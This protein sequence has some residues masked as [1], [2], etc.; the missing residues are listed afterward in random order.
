MRLY[1]DEGRVLDPVSDL[2]SVVYKPGNR[3]RVTYILVDSI[4]SSPSGTQNA[5]YSVRIK[6]LQPVLVKPIMSAGEVASPIENEDPVKLLSTPWFGG[7]YLNMEFKL[8][9]EN[10][11][12]K[13]AWLMVVDTTKMENGSLNTYLTFIHDA[14]GDGRAKTTLTLVSFDCNNLPYRHQS[15]SLVIRLF[16]WDDSGR[17]FHHELRI[18]NTM[19]GDSLLVKPRSIR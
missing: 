3:F 9:Y 10:P 19:Q 15:D 13:H 6:D 1:S 14:R 17:E 11:T 4:N 7:G 5:F 16:E 12:I 18:K 2:D 8:K